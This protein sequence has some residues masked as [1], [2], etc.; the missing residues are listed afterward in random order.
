M[1]CQKSIA[2]WKRVWEFI[3]CQ[4]ICYKF[5]NLT[6]TIT[7]KR[8]CWCYFKTILLSYVCIYV[9]QELLQNI[10]KH[11]KYLTNSMFSVFF[12][13]MLLTPS[14]VWILNNS[15]LLSLWIVLM[16]YLTDHVPWF[17]CIKRYDNTVHTNIRVNQRRH[18]HHTHTH[19][20][21]T[22]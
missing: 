14:T 4:R 22:V 5:N 16:K 9:R 6:I 19:V 10:N 21:G 8:L 12:F 1:T 17:T 7:L 20:Q 11:T 15:F 3:A 2:W 18:T 13:M